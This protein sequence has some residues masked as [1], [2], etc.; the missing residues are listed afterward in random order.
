MIVTGRRTSINQFIERQ[1][2][3]W[4]QIVS[5][6]TVSYPS[7]EWPGRHEFRGQTGAESFFELHL[8]LSSV[9]C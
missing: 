2:P 6:L 7:P 9:L 1:T 8:C 5:T 4:Q 3:D